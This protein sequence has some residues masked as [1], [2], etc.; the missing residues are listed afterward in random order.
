MPKVKQP[1]GGSVCLACS[2]RVYSPSGKKGLEIELALSFA[3]QSMWLLAHNP[4]DRKLRKGN[5]DIR[6]VFSFPLFSQ[7]GI[8]SHGMVCHLHSGQTHSS[9]YLP[10]ICSHRHNQSCAS[11][12]LSQFLIKINHHTMQF[13]KQASNRT[14]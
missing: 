9:V 7:S 11:R 3:S 6:L 2:L 10:P 14:T 12:I 1:S 13:C 5:G 4:T 8:P